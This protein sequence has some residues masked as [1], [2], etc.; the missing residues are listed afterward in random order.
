MQPGRGSGAGALCGRLGLNQP[1][2]LL[3]LVRVR[4][5]IRIRVRVRTE[6]RASVK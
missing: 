4:V 6:V 5:R 2:D 1:D 3:D